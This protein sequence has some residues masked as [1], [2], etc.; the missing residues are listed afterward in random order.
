MTTDTGADLLR[1]A[2]ALLDLERFEQAAELYVRYLAEEPGNAWAWGDLARCK[3]RTGDREGALAAA[4]AAVAADPQCDYAW[5]MR[6]FVLPLLGRLDEAV[7]ASRTAVRLGPE[8]A[9][10]HSMLARSL[11]IAADHEGAFQAALKAVELRPDDAGL[12]FN[13]AHPAHRTGRHDIREKALLE[14]L[15]LDPQNAD[16]RAQLAELRDEAGRIKLPEL[17]GEYTAALGTRPDAHYIELKLNELVLRLLR[18]TRWF[19]LLCLVIAAQAGRVFPTGDAPTALPVPLGIRLW[20]LALMALA[21]ALGAW[22]LAYRKLPRGAR[23]AVWS[24]LRRYWPARLP[25][26]HAL[27]GTVCAVAL[28]LVPWTDRGDAQ[29]LAVVGAVPVVI[30]MWFGN[31]WRREEKHRREKAHAPKKA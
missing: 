10:N 22:F 25:L 15:R 30:P 12:H 28:V 9:N 21:W 19:A 18:R 3:V 27:W 31:A 23:S 20:A 8:E 13:L 1:R 2:G 14:C 24:L 7:E 26:A 29:V 17:A 16:A 4:D 5:R 11:V 6:A